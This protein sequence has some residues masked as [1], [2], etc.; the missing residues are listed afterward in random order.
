MTVLVL[1]GNENQAVAA[2]RSLA[3]AG[4]RVLVGAETAWS[5]AGWSRH[6]AGTFVYPSPSDDV[7]GFVARVVQLARND[8]GVFVLPMTERTLLPLSRER[9]RLADLATFVLPAHDRVLE[10]CSKD[11]TTRL[12]SSLGIVVPR[13]WTLG[14]SAVEAKELARELP[15]P[16]VLKPAM[17]HEPGDGI[18]RSTGAPV[19]ARH[20][21]QFIDAQRE[22]ATRCRTIIVQE[23]VAGRGARVA[24]RGDGGIS[25][26]RRWRAGIP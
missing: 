22:L 7:D 10:A 17:S 1:D 8:G 4:H 20:A 3:R 21:E 14:G 2:T 11:R 26:A 19:Y 24:R 6:A 23:F 9:A 12:A 15:Y 18:V 13:T 25:C 16:V 5:K